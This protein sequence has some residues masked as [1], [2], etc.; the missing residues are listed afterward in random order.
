MGDPIYVHPR[1]PALRV[2]IVEPNHALVLQVGG[3]L[4]SG[5]SSAKNT[6]QQ[7]PDLS[8][9]FVVKEAEGQQSRLFS[10]YR[11]DYGPGWVRALGYGP[12][13]TEPIGFVMDLK[14]LAGIRWRAERAAGT[15]RVL[16]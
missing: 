2:A 9:A 8:W 1:M 5:Q 3:E 16:A 11:V 14:M 4:T 15:G 7:P 13:I 6:D 12:W 10:R